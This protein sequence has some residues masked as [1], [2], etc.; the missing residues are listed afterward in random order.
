MTSTS[1]IGPV[2]VRNLV[3][4]TA[5]EVVGAG[6][7]LA[8]LV[9]VAR[10]L[11]VEGYGQFAYV[12]ALVA[13]FQVV[14]EAGLSRILIRDIAVALDEAEHHFGAAK[15]LT[16][17]FSVLTFLLVAAL[18]QLLHPELELRLA[19]YLTGA[20]LIA[21]IHA[22]CYG[23]VFRA[24]EEM[25]VN[26]LGFVFHKLVFLALVLLAA[27]SG[28]G[29][30]AMCSALLLANVFL[31]LYYYAALTRR[32][33]RPRIR[34]DLPAWRR[35]M[36]EAA[37]LGMSEM[38]RRMSWHVD[39]LLLAWLGSSG[40]AGYF[41]AGQKI[42]QA[43]N[44]IPRTL[45]HVLLPVLS[46]LASNRSETLP[47]VVERA[48]AGLFF[49]ALP[50]ALGLAIPARRIV[51]M[52]YGAPFAP[53]AT[54]LAI[55][56]VALL[57][58]FPMALLIVLFTAIGAQRFLTIA[59]LIGLGVHVV[60]DLLLIPRLGHTGASLG[61]LL[62]EVVPLPLCYAY[63]RRRNQ[64]PACFR[65][66]WRVSVAGSALCAILLIV[67]TASLPLFL[68]GTLAGVGLYAWLLIVLRA[69]LPEELGLLV[70]DIRR[71]FRGAPATARQ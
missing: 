18:A 7:H 71:R 63:L 16:W 30:L 14:A 51:E 31:C 23:A 19:I 13:A 62:A 47:H 17:A 54:S 15:S 26:A 11:G 24:F 46:R 5:G 39:V 65:W 36:R 34:I 29:L 57:F 42:T 2:V 60:A 38:F 49:L 67:Q 70:S 41:S 48:T 58:A 10:S 64:H 52:A 6:I 33:F 43:L 20:A 4:T 3:A 1:R 28:R 32:H 25:H 55:L 8:T 44:L 68:L 61:A 27:W 50:L 21:M 66:F 9:L 37:P 22:V 12:L 40:A 53:A 56:A 69:V 45:A 35:M 59:I